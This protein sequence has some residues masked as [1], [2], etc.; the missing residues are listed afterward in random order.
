MNI[1]T[2]EAENAISLAAERAHVLFDKY[3]WEYFDGPP[4]LPRLKETIRSLVENLDADS[5]VETTATGRFVVRKV[6]RGRAIE[7]CLDLAQFST[8]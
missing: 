6:H 5:K 2:V 7:I 3:G 8:D 1:E 4:T